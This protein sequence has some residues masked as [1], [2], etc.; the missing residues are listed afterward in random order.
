VRRRGGAAGNRSKFIVYDGL[1]DA[2]RQAPGH[3]NNGYD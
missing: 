2:G 1:L 3:E